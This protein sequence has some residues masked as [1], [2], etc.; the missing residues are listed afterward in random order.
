[1]T[2]LN[3]P[4]LTQPGLAP[5]RTPGL[6]ERLSRNLAARRKALHLTQA[7]LAERLGVDT[8]TISRF[9]RGKHLPSLATLEHLAKELMLPLSELIEASAPRPID[10]CLRLTAWMAPLAEPERRFVLE[11]VRACCEHLAR[12]D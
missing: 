6:A 11:M 8:E 5:E 7:Q 2:A 12:R 9:E 4:T 1:M 10:D 3:T